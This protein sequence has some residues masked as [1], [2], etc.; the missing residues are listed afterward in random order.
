MDEYARA[1]ET[2]KEQWEAFAG[3]RQD[4]AFFRAQRPT[5]VAWKVRDMDELLERFAALRGQCDQI[6]WGWIN[7]R[8]L[9]TLHLAHGTLPWQITLVKLMQ[10]KPGAA[11]P[12]GLDHIDFYH[13][14]NAPER[15]EAEPG[16]RWNSEVNGQTCRWLSVWFAGTEAKLRTDTVMHVCAAEMEGIGQMII[17]A[18]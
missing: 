16:L 13:P 11:D 12:T 3:S 5:A 2:Y 14:G 4:K 18:T 1:I 9:L 8:W 15:L 10:R 7:G 6:H 17:A